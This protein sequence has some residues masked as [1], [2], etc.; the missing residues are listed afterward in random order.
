MYNVQLEEFCKA[1]NLGEIVESKLFPI[2]MANRTYLVET[3]TDKYVI[4]AINPTKVRTPKKI[5]RLEIAE[6]IAEIASRNGV[7]SIVVIRINGKIITEFLGQHYIVFKFFDGEVI[8]LNKLTQQHCFKAGKLLATLHS[9]KF[10]GISRR[11]IPKCNYGKKPNGNIDWDTYYQEIAKIAPKWLSLLEENLSLLN[12]MFELSYE[13]HLNFIPAD[14]VISHG[15]VS[16]LNM[17]WKDGIPYFLDWE[18]SGYIDAT[19]ECLYAAIRFSSEKDPENNQ[20]RILNM[21]KIFSFFEGYIEKRALKFENLNT[22]L[23]MIYYKRL[24]ILQRHFQKYIEATKDSERKHSER[25]IIPFLGL[26]KS[27]EDLEGQ[28]EMMK[29][30]VKYFQMKKE[31]KENFVREIKQEIKNEILEELS[32][33][34]KGKFSFKS[35]FRTK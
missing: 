2:G 27:F 19:Y 12:T 9:T 33:E 28:L 15:D 3:K 31:I 24:S 13:I 14:K 29:D 11:D 26:L 21:E 6:Q 22:A 25:V 5:K 30:K 23:Y 20:K 1:Y 8:H 10:T 16:N 34:Q 4:K 17:M 35:L 32:Q 7:S 18:T